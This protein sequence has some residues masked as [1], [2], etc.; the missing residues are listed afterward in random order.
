[1]YNTHVPPLYKSFEY[2]TIPHV[3][4]V[5]WLGLETADPSRRKQKKSKQRVLQP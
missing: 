5:F 2:I 1:M 3:L 4:L